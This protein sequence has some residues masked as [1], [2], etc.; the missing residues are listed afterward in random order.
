ETPVAFAAMAE[1]LA[2]HGFVVAISPLMGTDS[3]FVRIDAQDLET[4]IRDLEFVI[5]QVRRLP[6]VSRE[7][8]GL[9]GFDMGGMAALVLTM[10]NPDVDAL[11]TADAGVLY[12]HPSGVPGELPDHDPSA[13]DVP[14][15]HATRSAAA[16]PPPGLSEGESLFA[17]AVHSDRY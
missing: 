15:L 10:R 1:Y 6:F 7:R 13:L 9:F 16:A 8:L 2:G 5:G 3:P 17:R 11:L 14:W 12:P 4:Q